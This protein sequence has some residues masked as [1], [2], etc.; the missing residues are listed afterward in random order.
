[1]GQIN[2]LVSINT[3]QLVI[4]LPNGGK[5][6]NP[7]NYVAMQDDQV[8]DPNELVMAE[9][10]TYVKP[11]DMLIWTIKSASIKHQVQFTSIEMTPQVVLESPVLFYN[12]RKCV[13]VI[14]KGIEKNKQIGYTV[15]FYLDG[16]PMITWYWDPFIESHKDDTGD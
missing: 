9:L 13:A 16:D 3:D 14:N 11:G 12:L 7:D 4:D 10:T 8:F 2:I 1:M 5:L 6:E 15:E